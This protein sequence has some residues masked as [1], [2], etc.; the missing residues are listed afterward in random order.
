MDLPLPEI[1]GWEATRQLKQD[2][3]TRRIPVIALTVHAMRS[4][5]ERAIQAGCDQF[6][7]K[8]VMFHRL[9]SKMESFLQRRNPK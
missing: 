5:L 9:I 4:D 3:T 7:T 6:E 8:P 2:Q 1:D